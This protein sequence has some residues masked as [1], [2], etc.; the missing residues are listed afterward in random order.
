MTQQI[1][2]TTEQ[3]EQWFVW[4]QQND[5]VDLGTAEHFGI[6]RATVAKW[7]IKN[8]WAA[9]A[10]KLDVR[11]QQAVDTKL[12][13]DKFSNIEVV[14]TL[15]KVIYEKL[16]RPGEDGKANLLVEPTLRDLIMFLQYEDDLL[17]M[18]PKDDAQ[19]I[20]Q[21]F[22]GTNGSEKAAAKLDRNLGVI[23]GQ[24][25]GHGDGNGA[26][27]KVGSTASRLSADN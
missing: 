26:G 8:N 15:K 14:R 11:L 17:G 5:H 2:A 9:R 10:K 13:A 7:R 3:R 22:Q 25:N 6:S 21:L 16:I 1:A 23:F 4:W 20:V 19:H 12:H 18:L 24:P 27:I